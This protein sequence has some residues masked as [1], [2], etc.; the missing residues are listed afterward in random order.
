VSLCEFKN[1]P[2]L[3]K[4]H[5]CPAEIWFEPFGA[6]SSILGIMSGSAYH[7]WQTLQIH[8]RQC[9]DS[10]TQS[11][12]YCAWNFRVHFLNDLFFSA[13]T[14]A[15]AASGQTLLNP[16]SSYSEKKGMMKMILPCVASSLSVSPTAY[17]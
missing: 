10:L 7:V 13:Q 12:K 8:G 1:S 2:G 4:K 9:L 6:Y 14:L 15:Q 3:I 17:F 16:W 5:L 11:Q